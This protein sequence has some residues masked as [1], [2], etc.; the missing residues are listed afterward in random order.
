[1]SSQTQPTILNSLSPLERC[2]PEILEQIAFSA[3]E[4]RLPGPPSSLLPLLVT[5]K[6]VNFALSPKTNNTLY[7]RIFALKFDTA[8][9]KRRL[10]ER[11]LTSRSLAFELRHR[12]E[13]L[14]RIRRGDIGDS[15]LLH[16]LWTVFLLLLEHD[17][18]NVLQL[19]EWAKASTFVLRVAERW[20]TGGY[21]PEFDE[22]A[23]GLVCRIIWELVREGQ[24]RIICG[25]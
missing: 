3:A 9:A 13:V 10:T 2:S 21:G 12:F 25:T 18:N 23:G 14:N 6:T 24:L 20:L 15:M 11:W 4:E 22:N 8:A 1:M 16:D 7:A 5:S 19:T 17:H